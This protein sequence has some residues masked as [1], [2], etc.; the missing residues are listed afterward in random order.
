MF[1]RALIAFLVLPGMVAVA[2]PLAWLALTSHTSV[3]HPM[4][5]VLL[6]G[7]FAALLV[8]VRDFYVS[9]R[10]TLAPWSPPAYLVEVGL[11]RYS[12][13]PMYVAV[14][15]ILAGWALAFGSSSLLVYAAAVLVAF[16]LRVVRA[17]EPFLAREHG[18]AW[19][20]YRRRVPR[21]L[22]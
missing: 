1:L 15:T 6:V 22:W 16:H 10:G 5:L 20:R 9:G 19:A 7:G 11:Y 8:C 13:N 14:V 3:V 21:W 18:E 12:R 2:V 17:E 4:A